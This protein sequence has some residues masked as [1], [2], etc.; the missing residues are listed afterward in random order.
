MATQPAISE[1]CQKVI[2]EIFDG[3]EEELEGARLK[4]RQTESQFA[5]QAVGPIERIYMDLGAKLREI[6]ARVPKGTA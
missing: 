6:R 3:V 1:E 2:D 5:D 4:I